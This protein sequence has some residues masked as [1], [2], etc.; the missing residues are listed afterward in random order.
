MAAAFHKNSNGK[1]HFH[2]PFLQDLNS[3]WFCCQYVTWIAIFVIGDQFLFWRKLSGQVVLDSCLWVKVTMPRSMRLQVNVLIV[4]ANPQIIYSHRN[5]VGKPK[6]QY[7]GTSL[8]MSEA[9]CS[10]WR[11]VKDFVKFLCHFYRYIYIATICIHNIVAKINRCDLLCHCNKIEP[12]IRFVMIVCSIVI[13]QAT[14]LFISSI[15][16]RR[17]RFCTMECSKT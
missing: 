14:N 5:A 12:K 17:Q 4:P 11:S 3:T 8:L 10:V 13:A 9:L 16:Q 2:V 7:M 6:L 1:E 15:F